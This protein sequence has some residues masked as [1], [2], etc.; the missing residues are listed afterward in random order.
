MW[1]IIGHQSTLAFFEHA[2]SLGHLAHAYLLTGPAQVGK[3]TL[4]LALGQ[5]LLCINEAAI[6]PG[7]PCGACQACRKAQNG[8]HPDLRIIRPAEDKKA[9]GINEIRAL[10]GA[11]ALQPQEG[12]YSIFVLPRAE[13]LT[14]EA[15]NALL[16]TLEEP[17]PQTI[18]FLTATDEQLLPAT[19]ISRCQVLPLGLVNTHEISAALVERRGLSQ[20]RARELSVL[21]AGRPGWAIAASQNPELQEQRAAWFELMETL[22]ASGPAQRM[23]IGAALARDTEQLDELLMVWLSWWH[24]VLFSLEGVPPSESQ[25]E[26]RLSHYTRQTR[27][28]AARQVIRQI[29]EA[30]QQ[31][32]QNAQPRLVLETLL[33][34]LP[35]MKAASG[36]HSRA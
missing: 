9:L 13:M 6:P 31:L 12:R 8:T 26:Q 36:Q 29:H 5:A 30:A 11:A 24:E 35:Q 23:K 22:C 33:L 4:A 28:D 20:E 34:E 15:A 32:E 25:R 27:P 18:L 14:T 19:V 17:P 10:I 21:A 2:H 1:N 16:K 7:S 3:R